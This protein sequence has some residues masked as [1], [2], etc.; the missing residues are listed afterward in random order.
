MLKWLQNLGS[1]KPLVTEN[2]KEWI[3]RAADESYEEEIKKFDFVTKSQGDMVQIFAFSQVW[4]ALVFLCGERQKELLPML[5]DNL[6]VFCTKI[7]DQDICNNEINADGMPF[8]RAIV[9]H[10]LIYGNSIQG[11]PLDVDLCNSAAIDYYESARIPLGKSTSEDYMLS[12]AR[13]A[14]FSKNLI[15]AKKCLKARNKP[16]Y[17]LEEIELLSQL[18]KGIESGVDLNSQLY[19]N[20]RKYFESIRPINVNRTPAGGEIFGLTRFDLIVLQQLYFEGK[21]QPNWEDACS[22]VSK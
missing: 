6:V 15:L 5:L 9:K 2:K 12:G 17:R 11:Q 20:W 22:E 4:D 1:T 10:A 19:E 16:V 13:L 7:L 14:L 3:G 21:S 8:N 18:I